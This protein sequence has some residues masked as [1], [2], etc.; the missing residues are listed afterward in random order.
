VKLVCGGCGA[1]P[2]AHDKLP[3]SCPNRGAGDVDHVLRREGLPRE[4]GISDE[5]NPFVRFRRLLLSYEIE[6]DDA[7]FVA[8]AELLDRSVYECDGRGFRVTPL[9]DAPS[10]AQA[11]GVARV[12]VKDETGN[13]AGSHKG[14]HLFGLALHL[15]AAAVPVSRPLAIASC[16][17]AALA[18]AVVARAAGRPLDVYIPPTADEEVVAALEKNGARIHRCPRAPGE[19]GDPC[20]HRFREAVASG[21]LPFSCQGGDAALTIE[22]GRTLGYELAQAPPPDRLFVQVG[23]GALASSLVQ[24]LGDAVALGWWPRL[25]TIHAVQTRGCFPLARAWERLAGRD[26]AAV[27]RSEVM[28]PWEEEPRSAAHGILDDET[29]DWLEIVRAMRATGGGPIVV[30]ED[31]VREANALGMAAGFAVDFTGSAGL[32]GALRLARDGELRRDERITV[33]FTGARR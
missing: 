2:P 19:R 16:G 9:T 15:E 32:A 14:R 11:L 22:G 25:P 20:Y 5:Q 29:Y 30:D 7:R 13:V 4:P 23:G 26:P 6:P 21:A 24:A 28:W 17:N 1:S 10:L 27:P 12:W 8:R 33:L 18:A 31:Q 3:L